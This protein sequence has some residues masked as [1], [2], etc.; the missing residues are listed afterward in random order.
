MRVCGL[1][2]LNGNPGIAN[3]FRKRKSQV[4]R[5]CGARSLFDGLEK[6]GDQG[7]NEFGFRKRDTVRRVAL[8]AAFLNKKSLSCWSTTFRND[9]LLFV[10]R[11]GLSLADEG[12]KRE[13]GERGTDKFIP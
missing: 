10:R 5:V 1:K 4:S 2:L 6:G 13:E 3:W 11:L 12:K 9:R 8:E 7:L